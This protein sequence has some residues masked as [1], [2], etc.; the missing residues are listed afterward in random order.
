[1]ARQ[2][3]FTLVEL[4]ASAAILI[5]VVSAL[6]MSMVAGI[7]LNSTVRERDQARE[8]ARDQLERV[9]SWDNYQTLP[10]TFDGTTF[11]VDGLVGP[12]DGATEPG[13]VTV[14]ATNPALLVI[15]VTVTWTDAMNT[16][17]VQLNTMLADTSP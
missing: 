4:M 9:L 14:D 3:G 15:A 10:T 2:G 17:F 13:L 6:A 11:P 5:V 7:Q 1:M 12:D 16:D 8:A